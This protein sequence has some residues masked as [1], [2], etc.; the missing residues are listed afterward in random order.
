MN[1]T[2]SLKKNIFYPPG[3]LLIWIVIFLE[4]ATY[5]MALVAMVFYGLEDSS[6]FHDSSQSLNKNLGIINTVILL[7]SGYF[8]AEAIKYVQSKNREKSKLYLGLTVLFGFLFIILKLYDYSEKLNAGIEITTNIFYTF[9]W[10]LTLF[11]LLHVVLGM[12]F[13]IYFY[14]KL[15]E[16]I[17]E[18]N[19]E[20][21]EASAAFWHM[22]D[23]IWL[24]I[25]PFIYLIY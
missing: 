17:T 8:M 20:N 2:V 11:H 1:D 16:T 13:I 4:L 3:G 18:G 24:L 7:S 22:C 14:I 19:L 12:L 10:F 9:Y 25:F 5:S 6:L 21:I 15:E 23:L